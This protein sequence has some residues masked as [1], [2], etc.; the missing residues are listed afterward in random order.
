MRAR[1]KLGQR[2][3]E[4]G[5]A[6]WFSPAECHTQM[7]VGRNSEF[8]SIDRMMERVRAQELIG[9]ARQQGGSGT[10]DKWRTG[11]AANEGPQAEPQ[12]RRRSNNA[13]L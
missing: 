12:H 8:Q 10:A 5:L 6:A 13:E 3:C 1:G 11:T 7:T 9:L 2:I 4:A